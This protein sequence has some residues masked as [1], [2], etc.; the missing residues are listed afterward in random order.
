MTSSI[1][2][3]DSPLVRP[4]G[5]SRTIDFGIVKPISNPEIYFEDNQSFED[6]YQLGVKLGEGGQ[7][8]VY[9]CQSKMTGKEFAVKVTRSSNEE[10][11]ETIR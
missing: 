3:D 4:K 10:I 11:I 5:R 2:T 9:E 8:V 6:H 1:Q 7:S